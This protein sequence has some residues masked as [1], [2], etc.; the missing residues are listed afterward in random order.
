M[1]IESLIVFAIVCLILIVAIRKLRRALKDTSSGCIG[2]CGMTSC[3]KNC[4]LNTR[5]EGEGAPAAVETSAQDGSAVSKQ[6]G[7]ANI[8]DKP[9][10]S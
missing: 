8:P 6:S 3:A 10:S 9:S 4:P 5:K 2:G 7:G 1:T